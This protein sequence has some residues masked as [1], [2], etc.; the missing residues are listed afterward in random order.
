MK[1]SYHQSGYIYLKNIF[2]EEELQH[3]E[4]ILTRFHKTWLQANDSQYKSGAINSHS[5]TSSKWISNEERLAIFKFI[6]QK[7]ISDIVSDIFPRKA[8]FLNTQLFFDPLSKRQNNYWHRDIQYTEMN[9]EQQ[10]ESI[11]T[12]NVLHFRIPFRSEP[13]IELVPGTHRKW[14]TPQELETR[15]SMNGRT[16]CD[17]LDTGIKVPLNR[18]D[19]LIFSANMI[20]RGLYGNNRFTLDIIFCDDSPEFRKFI[21]IRNHPQPEELPFLN[22]SLF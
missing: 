21:D 2:S 11:L 17:D 9:M 13:G 8:V 6:S 1:D 3:L 15:L 16:P 22:T 19:L 4:S 5:I 7:K 18:G 12:Q 20:H 14:D 10:K